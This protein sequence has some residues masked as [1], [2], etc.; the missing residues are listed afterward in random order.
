MGE[1]ARK[2]AFQKSTGSWVIVAP[3]GDGYEVAETLDPEDASN[4][5]GEAYDLARAHPKAS[6]ELKPKLD[7]YRDNMLNEPTG[8]LDENGK[9]TA[10]PQPA[11]DNATA[12]PANDNAA[13]VRPS[14][15]AE[16][17]KP[18][19]VW[20]AL[21]KSGKSF[22]TD[23]GNAGAATFGDGP[24]VQ[25]PP[26]WLRSDD[27]EDA[28]RGVGQGASFR[29]GDELSAGLEA[30]DATLTAGMEDLPSAQRRSGRSFDAPLMS[31]D[32][33][34]D[35]YYN[36][37]LDRNRTAD[38]TS[39]ERSPWLYGAGE[40]VGMTPA[41]IA[42]APLFGT[43]GAAKGAA[44]VP[45]KTLALR[46]AGQGAVTGA[47]TGAGG[48]TEGNR[49]SSS[50]IGAGTGAAGGFA[51]S[52]IG[53]GIGATARWAGD[54]VDDAVNAVKDTAPVRAMSDWFGDTANAWRNDAVGGFG[55]RA[56]VVAE[57]EGVDFLENGFADAV[58]R[59]MPA[60]PGWLGIPKPRTAKDYQGAATDA[61]RTVGGQQDEA[62]DALTAQG[63]S[64]PLR[65]D[66]AERGVLD[67]L[68]GSIGEMRAKPSLPDNAATRLEALGGLRDKVARDL[69]EETFEAVPMTQAG[70]RPARTALPEEATAAGRRRIDPLTL[71]QV[72][73]DVPRDALGVPL[74]TSS[75]AAPRMPPQNPRRQ[76]DPLTL[77]ATR[78]PAP[79]V[80]VRTMQRVK[81]DYDAEGY[82]PHP[83]RG[84]PQGAAKTANRDVADS[85][86]GAMKDAINDNALRS[87]EG[88]QAASRYNS[89][90]RDYG[91]MKVA[92]AL[93]NREV[94]DQAGGTPARSLY[95]AVTEPL[96]ENYGA[97]ILANTFRGA[98]RATQLQHGPAVAP[99]PALQQVTQT[100][101]ARAGVPWGSLV[102]QGQPAMA[103]GAPKVEIGEAQITSRPQQRAETSNGHDV[104]RQVTDALKAYPQALGPFKEQLRAVE[105]DPVA[106]SAAI[107]DLMS[108]PKFRDKVVPELQAV[109]AA[110]NA[111][112]RP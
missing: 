62:L 86:R 6:T 71:G 9:T 3:A 60:E 77:T 98:Q 64:A 101:G 95:E 2:L 87:T 5:T 15:V 56:Q 96:R 52:A 36:E 24:L 99:S 57:K 53:S 91:P 85:V 63:V 14:P 51:G 22:L 110:R 12:A 59:R 47:I 109:D 103:Q 105:T 18:S 93:A 74:H 43:A 67:G 32:E 40:A 19:S 65:G 48:G 23:L 54:K 79:R 4:W 20:G 13:P 89:A 112:G 102:R 111:K 49:L 29:F 26:A 55:G 42:S 78:P 94:V 88:A 33:R 92:Q 83:L 84:T 45:W 17:D 37:A 39:Q 1:P 50:A 21:A 90:A 28:A 34:E 11:N 30:A 27:A 31:D 100:A 35:A 44:V 69:G 82:V 72:S 41:T 66:A 75:A 61:L 8:P 46:S 73:E 97:D 38:A 107:S 7:W 10:T 80:P 16:D 76:L 108:E 25:E 81:Q 70:G 68:E 58:E 104:Q 106:L